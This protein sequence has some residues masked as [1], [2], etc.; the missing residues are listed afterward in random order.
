MEL[1]TEAR[2]VIWFTMNSCTVCVGVASFHSVYAVRNYRPCAIRKVK[3]VLELV[4]LA[5]GCYVVSSSENTGL[6][7]IRNNV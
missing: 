2:E 5:P 4:R 3:P 7:S 6:S 1:A